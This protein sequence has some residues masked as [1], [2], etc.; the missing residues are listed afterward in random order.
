MA[1]STKLILCAHISATSTNPLALSQIPSWMHKSPPYSQMHK[2]LI[3][4]AL[5]MQ[6]F[7]WV[8]HPPHPQ[9][10]QFMLNSTNP[11]EGT[12]PR[13]VGKSK[14][15]AHNYHHHHR[16]GPPDLMGN[17][18]CWTRWGR[19]R[20]TSSLKRVANTRPASQPARYRSWSGVIHSVWLSR[21]LRSE[22]ATH[23]LAPLWWILWGAYLSHVP[24]GKWC[25]VKPVLKSLKMLTM[26]VILC[27]YK[28]EFWF[29]K[30]Q[31]ETYNSQN[32]V[33]S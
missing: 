7:H 18:S 11:R 1:L 27:L 2:I 13:A 14:L 32:N 28:M 25:H 31:F 33:V 5:W 24:L 20:T 8:N 10:P 26:F 15:T 12:P 21:G 19:W 17:K 29:N 6:P 9:R 3:I 23:C 4:L 30:W 22:E 16:R